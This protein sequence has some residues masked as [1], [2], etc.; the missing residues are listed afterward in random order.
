M[1]PVFFPH[2]KF[3]L[4]RH[5]SAGTIFL[6]LLMPFNPLGQ[7]SVFGHPVFEMPLFIDFHSRHCFLA[8]REG[9]SPAKNKSL[10]PD[11]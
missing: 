11:R 1:F 9:V 5:F 7:C 3:D 6:V 10:P 4:F 2:F 8:D